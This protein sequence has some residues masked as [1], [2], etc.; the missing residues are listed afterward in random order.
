[1]TFLA[2]Q[3][4]TLLTGWW[5]VFAFLFYNPFAI[6]LNFYGLLAAPL[7]AGSLGAIDL[8]DIRTATA[9]EEDFEGLYD[10]LPTWLSNLSEEELRLVLDDIDYYAVLGVSKT[11]H[12]EEIKAAYRREA[13]QHHPDTSNGQ[14]DSYRIGVIITANRVL[15]DNRLRAAYDHAQVGAQ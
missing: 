13:K 9:H 5:G 14:S 10:S 2:R 3:G 7:S 15:G 4:A 11:A 8:D 1:M 6:A 12:A